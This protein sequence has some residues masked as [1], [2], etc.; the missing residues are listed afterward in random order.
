MSGT[1]TPSQD[2]QPVQLGTNWVPTGYQL[3]TNWV[4]TGYVPKSE[5]VSRKCGNTPLAK[6]LTPIAKHLNTIGCLDCNVD[7]AKDCEAGKK[8]CVLR[9]DT[10]LRYVAKKKK[11]KKKNKCRE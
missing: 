10:L 9:L 7:F 4:P 1:P 8:I 11:K 2:P 3:G 5:P 6:H